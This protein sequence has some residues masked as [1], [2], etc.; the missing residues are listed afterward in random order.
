M[1]T[2]EAGGAAG[3][4]ETVLIG[5]Y[6]LLDGASGAVSAGS[7]PVCYGVSYGG[8]FGAGVIAAEC[9]RNASTM[10]MVGTENLAAIP[11]A[12]ATR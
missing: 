8:G 3:G 12:D 10:L 5:V 11:G 6:F 2:V 4:D 1:V 7:M 9:G